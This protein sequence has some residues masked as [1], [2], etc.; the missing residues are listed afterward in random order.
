MGL[1]RLANVAIVGALF[2][3]LAPLSNAREWADSTGKY[4]IE[5]N[6]VRVEKGNAVLRKTNGSIVSIP[7]VRLSN[8]DQA[9]LNAAMNSKAEAEDPPPERSPVAAPAPTE[10]EILTQL[11]RPAKPQAFNGVALKTVIATLLGDEIPLVIDAKTLAIIG[12]NPN[13]PVTFES[14]KQASILVNL[15]A[16]LA[17]ANMGVA[18]KDGVVLVT[19]ADEANALIGVSLYRLN[20]P[21]NYDALINRITTKLEPETW[22]DVGGAG[23]IAPIPPVYLAVSQTLPMRLKIADTYA[24]SMKIVSPPARRNTKEAGAAAAL[25]SLTKFTF[26]DTPL[27]D[28]LAILA[29]KHDVEFKI[30]ADALTT[31]GLSNNTP[32][33]L[34]IENAKLKAALWIALRDLELAAI[35]TDDAI[36]VTSRDRAENELVDRSYSYGQFARNGKELVKAIQ[37]IEPASWSELGGASKITAGRTAIEVSAPLAVHDKIATLMASLGIR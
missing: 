2:F 36:M 15:N 21:Q 24:T 33:T 31:L 30:D 7:I 6:L 22:A 5:A 8:A 23:A 18:L 26:L 17:P 34:K 4:R 35:A 37:L 16:M 27:K 20:R 9:F 3:A 14:R 25:N 1:Q 11:M 12:R 13:A 28:A 32:I 10:S 29:D 19:S